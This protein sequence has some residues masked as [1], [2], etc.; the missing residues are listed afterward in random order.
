MTEVVPP[1]T[2]VRTAAP[3]VFGGIDR[4]LPE[5]PE[6]ARPDFTG[7]HASAEFGEL[8]HRFRAFVFPMSALFFVWYLTYVLLTVYARGL[9]G[10]QLVGSVN[11][12]LVLGL[13]QFAS[14]ITITVVYLRYARRR[15]DPMTRLIRARAG[16]RDT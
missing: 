9:M 2:A 7:I 11:V 6:Y 10:V 3:V 16:V 15:L 5:R 1:S 12:G 8:R 14:T 13:L 4:T